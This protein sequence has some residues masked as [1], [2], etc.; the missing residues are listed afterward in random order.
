M[1]TTCPSCG[2]EISGEARFCPSCGEQVGQVTCSCGAAIPSG[3]AVCPNCG[4]PVDEGGTATM[5][6]RA[7][8]RRDAGIRW[9]RNDHAVATRVT[10]SDLKG[11]LS[12]GLE[13][14]PGTRALLFVGGRYVGTL[15]PGRHTIE[16]LAKKLK[17][18]TGGEPAALIVD[19][20]ELGLAFEVD[21]LHSSDHHDVTLA[22]EASLRLVE[23]E[24]FLANVMR[25]RAVFTV[26]GLAAF[27]AGEI[28]QSLRE[29]VARHPAKELSSG[30][31][32]ARLEMELLS[33]WKATLDRSGFVL[34]RFRVLRFLSP[35]LEEAEDLRTGGHDGAVVAEASREAGQ[36]LFE[37]E[38]ADLRWETETVRRRGEAEL[39]RKGVDIELELEDLGKDVDRLERRR[40][41][42]ERLLSEQVLEK[43]TTLKS[44]EEW[45]KLRL[46]VDRDR[47]L[48]EHEWEELRKDLEGKAAE[49][50]VQ[51]QLA[52]ERLRAM[53]RADLEELALKRQYQL[54]L[55]EMRGD[56][57]VVREQVERAR[58][59]LDAE[60]AERTRVF[61]QRMAEREQSFA[62]DEKE[63]RSVAELQMWKLE[64]LEANRQLAKDREAARQLQLEVTRAEQERKR[65][66]QL[67]ELTLGKT[68]A[69]TLA[70]GVMTGAGSV[71]GHD[72]AEAIRAEKG[73]EAAERE[74][75]LLRESRD[76]EAALLQRQQEL[77]QKKFETAVEAGA[78]HKVRRE[79]LDEQ[80]KDRLERVSTAGLTADDKQRGP[81]AWCEK[82]RLKFSAARGC[83]LCAQ[84]R[85]GE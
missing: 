63:Q 6:R 31:L 22:A 23:P 47:A 14:Q 1:K 42:F 77:D 84:E 68:A 40:P 34:N 13:V 41:V 85:E 49:K 80:E 30:T 62:Q 33:A 11:R 18:P 15:A 45:R 56:T 9:V 44:E 61:E 78:R 52:F 59:E 19:D 79:A 83:P 32:R 17:I 51:R 26:D 8:R 28:R 7:R 38:L 46:Q 48:D 82:H 39:E 65:L 37:E 2:A 24:L 69:E 55:L 57:E 27:L 21:G 70:A 73:A 35:A 12:T 43:I 66:A 25:D 74:A 5:G 53:A 36:V 67:G 16:S 10:P 71:S 81:L 3:A 64:R 20:G 29:M 76:R 50:E 75:A 72:V 4:R 60:L 54:K 58:I